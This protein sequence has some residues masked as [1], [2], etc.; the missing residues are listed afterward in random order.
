MNDDYITG[1]RKD[2]V[3]A[4]ARQQ[5][6]GRAARVARPLRPR[7]WSPLAV[8]GAAA[9]AA[10]VLVVVLGIR[11]ILPP[12]Q[13]ADPKILADVPHRRPAARRRGSR[14]RA[15]GRR[16]RRERSSARHAGRQGAQ[17]AP[18][19]R[20]AGVDRGRRR[21]RV[22]HDDRRGRTPVTL[23]PPQ[24]R[25]TE[26]A[27]AR[28]RRGQGLWGRDRRRRGRPVGDADLHRGG[29]ARIDLRSFERTGFIPGAETAGLAATERSLWTRHL[30]SVF[31][32][33]A[34]GRVI[35]RVDGISPTLGFTSQRTLLAD[36]DG[37]WVV[38]QSDGQLYRIERGRVVRRLAVGQTAGV[39]R[40][41]RVGHLG[42]RELRRRSLRARPRRSRRGQGDGPRRRRPAAAADDRAGRQAAVGGHGRRRRAARQPGVISPLS[43]A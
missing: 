4:A 7:A 11:A 18:R 21:R 8:L 14:W 40:T 25:L 32:R 19:G 17:A 36:A 42:Q 26:R 27:P 6:R 23:Q 33:D 31:E 20:D 28:A 1:L 10:T 37:A 24:A 22:G 16:L 13:P 15:A 35:N 29:I 43:Y 12:P 9:T 38:G 30:D 3:A 34:R 5:Q 41:R 2:L 39:D